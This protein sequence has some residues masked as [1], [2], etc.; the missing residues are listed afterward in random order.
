MADVPQIGPLVAALRARVIDAN[1]I[2]PL[3]NLLQPEFGRIVWSRC[4]GALDNLAL[5]AAAR[6][7]V[8]LATLSSLTTTITTIDT[9]RTTTTTTTT[10]RT[11]TTTDA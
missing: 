10:T 11:T 5:D 3:V 2:G 7:Q 8:T 6:D 4:A 9:T 1:G